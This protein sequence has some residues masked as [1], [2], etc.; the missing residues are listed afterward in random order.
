MKAKPKMYNCPVEAALDVMGGKW[1]PLI[2]WWLH[3][4]GTQRFGELRKL[5]PAITEKMLS[6][7]LREMERDGI[8]SRT[9]YPEVPPKVEYR[10]TEYG[11]SLKRSLNALCD[12][13][14]AHVARTG[15]QI[16]PYR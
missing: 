11:R 6:H 12:W 13:G 8:V 10:L 3:S 16:R 15:A 2:L 9:V 7:Q 5:M 4:K 14:V 1:K